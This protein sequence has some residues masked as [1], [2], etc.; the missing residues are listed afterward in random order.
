MKHLFEALGLLW[1]ITNGGESMDYKINT[2][3]LV[4]HNIFEAVLVMACELKQGPPGQNKD[5][6]LMRPL[7]DMNFP[8]FVFE[9]FLGLIADFFPGLDCPRVH[10][11]K[12]N[13]AM[14]GVPS[15][16]KHIQ[17]PH[18]VG[19]DGV[20]G[21]KEVGI[22]L[23][24][25]LKALLAIHIGQMTPLW[26]LT[27]WWLST[28]FSGS[29]CGGMID[30]YVK[31]QAQLPG[32][33][34]LGRS[35]PTTSTVQYSFAAQVGGLWFLWGETG[36]SKTEKIQNYSSTL[37]PTMNVS[38]AIPPWMCRGA[39]K[40]AQDRLLEYPSAFDLQ[41]YHLSRVVADAGVARSKLSEFMDAIKRFSLVNRSGAK[42]TKSDREQPTNPLSSTKRWLN[43]SNMLD[44]EGG[45]GNKGNSL[46]VPLAISSNARPTSSEAILDSTR[47]DISAGEG[48][49]RERPDSVSS[50]ATLTESSRRVGGA[51][52]E[53]ER[54]EKMMRLKRGRL[55]SQSPDSEGVV[56]P[57]MMEAIDLLVKDFNR[58]SVTVDGDKES[59]ED[60]SAIF[61][62]LIAQINEARDSV[63]PQ[64]PVPK[65]GKFSS[66]G[67]VE[68]QS[69]PP[70]FVSNPT[71]EG[72][73]ERRRKHSLPT[74]KML[75]NSTD[76]ASTQ[77]STSSSSTSLDTSFLYRLSS[78][79]GSSHDDPEAMLALKTLGTCLSIL[80]TLLVT[81]DDND[82]LKTIIRIPTQPLLA[83]LEPPGGESDWDSGVDNTRLHSSSDALSQPQ[84]QQLLQ[85]TSSADNSR[86]SSISGPFLEVAKK[87]CGLSFHSEA[88]DSSSSR[89]L[90]STNLHGQP[91]T[92]LEARH[93]V[94]KMLAIA[95]QDA[96]RPEN[97]TNGMICLANLAQ[98]DVDSHPLLV[99]A[100][101]AEKLGG[102]VFDGLRTRFHATR[103]TWG[104]DESICKVMTFLGRWLETPGWGEFRESGQFQEQLGVLVQM[105]RVM[106][107]RR[108]TTPHHEHLYELYKNMVVGGHLPVTLEKAIYL[109]A[110]QLHIETVLHDSGEELSPVATNGSSSLA[111]SSRKTLKSRQTLP[112]LYCTKAT[113]VTKRVSAQMAEFEELSERN[114][115]H[116]YGTIGWEDI[117]GSVAKQLMGIS[118]QHLVFLDEKSK[119][120]VGQYSLQDLGGFIHD[121][122]DPCIFT[123]K[124]KDFSLKVQ[125]ETSTMAWEIQNMLEPSHDVHFLNGQDDL[126][127]WAE[128]DTQT[129]AMEPPKDS[130]SSPS[131]AESGE[132][133]Q[134]G[135]AV[136]PV[137]TPPDPNITTTTTSLSTSH[138]TNGHVEG[139]GLFTRTMDL[140][141][142]K[143]KEVLKCTEEVARQMTLIDHAQLCK[144][145]ALELLQKVNMVPKPQSQRNSKMSSQ[146]L[147]SS[148]SL[149]SLEQSETAIEK[150]AGLQVGNWVAHCILQH[151]ELDKRVTAV[152]Q[153]I[154]IAKQCL[155]F[156]NYS[157]VMAV[158]VA[159]LG[160]APIRRLHKT[161]EEMD[162]LQGT[163]TSD[164]GIVLVPFP[165]QLCPTEAR[166]PARRLLPL[167]PTCTSAP[168]TIP[169]IHSKGAGKHKEIAEGVVSQVEQRRQTTPHHEHLYELMGHWVLKERHSCASYQKKLLQLGIDQTVK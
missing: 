61:D 4:N 91:V 16:G 30:T 54:E 74:I 51:I 63:S 154:L 25:V 145:S 159:G 19:K 59:Q 107:Q 83:Y 76:S 92:Y 110:L 1:G 116:R 43:D 150:L 67:V 31:Q 60:T 103:V 48:G 46:Y 131:S 105:L 157:S 133:A 6:V 106:E 108:Q 169:P 129:F 47:T 79:S 41:S 11:P 90:V 167:P 12:F 158:V 155:E 104:Q 66:G 2:A 71:V 112:A 69:A 156:N 99:Q 96:A 138:T 127:E 122:T 84:Q 147:Q 24:Y 22:Q 7:R 35:P 78:A 86:P 57:S 21:S 37:L 81:E 36:T 32:L 33:L 168:F 17:L 142:L 101:L 109:S 151:R 152:H 64:S 125:A 10:Y 77:I 44:E 58:L 87:G 165:P 56:G 97:V 50:M 121:K 120:L 144:I 149:S 80:N 18:R 68:A 160:S 8:K 128:L 13:D 148:L 111:R 139:E 113:N 132:L 124:I 94:L 28:G 161:W 93:I 82:Y 119:E 88:S 143:L 9:V 102:L 45:E 126:D 115:K 23:C 53:E 162:L 27:L 114:G 153:F 146:S 62:S 136:S 5:V 166:F 34:N 89:S 140:Q 135:A 85:P 55:L 130:A 95:L 75:G 20:C 49:A 38:P 73:P 72:A 123:L 15:D 39:W 163:T 65:E 137:A 141:N 117:K 98:N 42:E 40:P 29:S 100:K 164:T 14:E 118:N 134:D 52:G 3:L 26:S 70:P